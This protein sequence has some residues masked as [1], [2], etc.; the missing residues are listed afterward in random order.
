MGHMSSRDR[1][2][3]GSASLLF[4]IAAGIMPASLAMEAVPPIVVDV[5]PI[6]VDIQ[7][8]PRPGPTITYLP[9]IDDYYPSASKAQGETGTVVIQ[10][11]YGENGRM[12]SAD[13]KHTSNILRLDQAA[14]QY[15]RQVRVKPDNRGGEYIPGC[16][17]IPV[18][19]RL[20]EP[21]ESEPQDPDSG[22]RER[23]P[24]HLLDSRRLS[25]SFS[26]DIP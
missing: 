16:I 19:F 3:A 2:T 6:L 11:C 26:G 4:L 9:S 5:P 7:V 22:T 10:A 15:A 21:D 24:R 20:S 1:K 25:T 17:D 23:L 14:Q 8:P 18:V 12:T 13:V